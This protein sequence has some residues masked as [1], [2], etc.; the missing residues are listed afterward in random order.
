MTDKLLNKISFFVTMVLFVAA[1]V[2]GLSLQAVKGNAQIVDEKY[3]VL[4]D[5]NKRV[6]KEKVENAFAEAKAIQ[7]SVLEI[8]AKKKSGF[9]PDHMSSRH[10]QY[11]IPGLRGTTRNEMSWNNG[12]TIL[13]VYVELEFNDSDAVKSLRH[14]MESISMGEFFLVRSFG[15]EAR[16]VKN[17]ESNKGMTNVGLHFVKGRAVVSIYFTNHKRTASKNEKVL[18]EVAR[19]VEPLIVAR[20]NFDDQ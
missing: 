18:M 15:E 17:V 20:P 2:F 6:P 7:D 19:L 12:N 10:L 3:Q 9:V 13:Q 16:L 11:D 14:G 8:I 4:L 5:R 1:L